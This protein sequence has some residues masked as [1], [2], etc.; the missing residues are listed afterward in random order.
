MDGLAVNAPALP[1]PH[2]ARKTGFVLVLLVHLVFIWA[3]VTGL[4]RKV[5]DEVRAPI[6][7]HVIEETPPPPPLEPV[8]PPPPQAPPPVY[9]PVP[10]IVVRAPPPPPVV[11]SAVVTQPP[12]P[13]PIVAAKPAP[14]PVVAPPA[15]KPVA[16]GPV[17]VATVCTRMGRPEMPGLSWS[18]EAGFIAD[19]TVVNGHVTEVKIRS[20]NV[21]SDR[22]ARRALERA[23][24][25]TLR[26]TYV[27]PGARGFQQEFRFKVE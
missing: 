27:C 5:F 21:V 23:I 2:P 1:E 20:L 13:A 17:Q 9:I 11:R 3:L 18:G 24:E 6:E 22:R 12:P 16:K 19:A 7:A 4:A 15:P 8:K 26:E 25:T 10:E 14:A